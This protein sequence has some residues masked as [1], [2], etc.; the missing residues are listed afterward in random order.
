MT[1]GAYAYGTESY[2]GTPSSTVTTFP[3]R[4]VEVEFTSGVWTDVSADV[5]SISTRRGRNRELGAFDTGSCS[6]TVRN[7]TRVYDPDH[8]S[9]PFYGNLRPN[10]RVRV[11]ATQAGVTYPVWQ[12]YVDRITQ[13]YGGP[14]DATATFDASDLFKLLNRT[15]LARSA[16][17]TEVLADSPSHWWRLDETA[18]ATVVV[19]ALGTANGTTGT[20]ATPVAFGAAGAPVR[21][22]G[23]AA[24]F[25]GTNWVSFG[26]T[27]LVTA[28]PYTFELWL[29]ITT[30]TAPGNNFFVTQAPDNAVVPNGQPFGF[31]TGTDVGSPGRVTWDACNSGTVRVDDNAWH[32]VALTADAAGA[33]T[34]YIDGASV[35]TGTATTPGQGSSRDLRIAYPASAPFVSVSRNGWVGDLDEF[36]TYPVALSAARVAAHNS[37]GRTPWNNEL[38]GTRLG[39]VLDQAAVPTGD[40]NIDAGTT[41]LQSTSLGGT[42]LAYAQKVEETEIGRFFVAKDG[43]VRFIGRQAADTGPYLTSLATLVDD[44]SGAGLPYVAVS[45]DVDE[46]T[47]VTR[48]TVSRDGSV[49]VSYGDT[50]AQAEFKIIDET[51]DG[52]LHNSDTYSLYY[53]QLVV[54]THKN[55]TTRIGAVQLELGKDPTNL[56]PA[57]LA[58]E[59]GDRVTYK[60]K[61]QNLGSVITIPMRV[62]AIAHDTGSKYWRTTLQLSPFNLGQS[63]YGTGV[64]DTSLW[65]QAVWGL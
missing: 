61:P 63:G 36:A 5:V 9:G 23:T 28:F 16:Y 53:A 43:T 54:N 8:T 62:E 11:R 20:T 7:D 4:A 6:F 31:V 35:A 21:D 44:D 39:R 17:A 10:R 64:W 34:L 13:V 37:A 59:I 14:N 32:H 65:D 26:T 25:D 2:A 57:I 18:G 24:T 47:V 19:D 48:A 29:K 42:A 60:R 15:E 3:Y 49:A 38:P 55:P 30:R 51:H 27:P 41:T 58:L 45:A 46:A 33:Q 22:G 40:R 12:G 56:Y 52:L 50:A 1:Y